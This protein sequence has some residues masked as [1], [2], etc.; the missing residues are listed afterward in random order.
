MSV[1]G[2]PAG[3]SSF[4]VLINLFQLTNVSPNTQLQC[5][6]ITLNVCDQAES[7]GL[8]VRNL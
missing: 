3:N 6:I 4:Y 5:T 8:T 2:Q 7:E 1:Y